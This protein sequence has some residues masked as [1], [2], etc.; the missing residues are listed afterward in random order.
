LHR[1]LKNYRRDV[2]HQLS[3]RIV[4]SQDIIFL[5]D[6]NVKEMT[7]SNKGTLDN[8]GTDVK[9]KSA[10]N[11]NI[12]SQGWGYLRVFICYKAKWAGKLFDDNVNPAYTSQK[13]YQCSYIDS[14]NREGEIFHC[15]RCHHT[16]H[17]DVNAAKNIL[18]DGLSRIASKSEQLRI[19]GL[20][21]LLGTLPQRTT[22]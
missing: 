11:K 20:L 2:L 19:L 9:R 17:A 8:P 22:A 15:L 14:N 12:C 3:R 4:D 5:E 16:D 21:G 1:K 10:L 13:C 7:K 18:R 6:L